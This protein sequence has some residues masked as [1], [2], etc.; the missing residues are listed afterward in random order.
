MIDV[1]QAATQITDESGQNIA[2]H[3]AALLD[4]AQ[5]PFAHVAVVTAHMHT[6]GAGYQIAGAA[7][8]VAAA[9]ARGIPVVSARQM[10]EWTDGRNASS[11]E[12][13]AFDGTALTFGVV[14][15]GGARNL[16]AMLPRRT[17]TH[18]LASLT[19]GGDSARQHH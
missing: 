11:F 9:Q 4:G 18:V 7:A 15:A 12:N 3:I 1:F 2:N 10:L 17:G 8:I 5:G 19:R 16:R 13:V 14:Q 6:D